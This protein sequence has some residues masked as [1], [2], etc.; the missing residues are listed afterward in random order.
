M[1]DL[2]KLLSVAE[3]ATRRGI[4]KEAVYALIRNGRLS[5]LRIAGKVVVRES[6][7]FAL[8]C[9]PEYINRS[10]GGKLGSKLGQQLTLSQRGARRH[11]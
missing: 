10:N 7:L 3:V 1:A 11:V 5:S 4:R 9:D 6:A 2:G 8:E